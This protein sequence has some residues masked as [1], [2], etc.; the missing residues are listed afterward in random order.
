MGEGEEKGEGKRERERERGTAHHHK[1]EQMR[2]YH[3]GKGG[4]PI[5]HKGR[6]G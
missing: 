4:R 2:I 1:D 6:V 5:H 3:I